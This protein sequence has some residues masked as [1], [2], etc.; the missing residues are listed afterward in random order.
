[1]NLSLPFAYSWRN[2]LA[3]KLSTAVTLLA[4][5]VAV[6]VFI[7]MTATASGIRNVAANTGAPD[8]VIVLSKGSS[9]VEASS[10]DRETVHRLS[11][12]PFVARGSNGERLVSVELLTAQAVRRKGATGSGGAAIRYVAVRGVT[13]AAFD[14][15]PGLRLTAGRLPREP[16]EIILGR[17]VPATLGDFVPGDEIVY[18]GIRH[19]IV[20]TFDA[21]GQ[22]F[23]GEIW[24]DLS[25][26]QNE[27]NRQ[28]VSTAVVRV[29]SPARIP[30]LL[31]NIEGSRSLRVEAK[32]EVAYYA[33]IRQASAAFV[34][35]G[36]VI[37]LIMGAGAVVAGMNTMYAAMSR[38][39]R[40]M[41]T[42]RAL[43]FGRFMVGGLVL[44]ESLLIALLGGVLGAAL[45]FAFDGYALNLV[46]LSFQLD[47][48]PSSLAYAAV[49]ALLIGLGGGL[50]PARAA[51][52]LDI[53]QALRHT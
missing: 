12:I 19:R 45:A 6:L 50:F 1:M 30:V 24:A 23:D 36:N 10:L 48:G 13:P 17:L 5:T 42:L 21:G 38:R 49:L 31:S 32:S 52:R 29:E 18:G 27:S 39:V 15:H 51:S 3:R 37:A 44:L 20:G 25:S 14:V 4:V 11:E 28:D 53:V 7:V 43:G 35:L 41:G 46:G 34:Y 40:E 33:N 16:G 8:N 47:V 22:V 26:L 2:M 9:S